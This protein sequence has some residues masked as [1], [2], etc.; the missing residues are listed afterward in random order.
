[1]VG[2]GLPFVLIF[3]KTDKLSRAAAQANIDAFLLRLQEIS[4][5]AP[6]VLTSSSTLSHGRSEILELIETTLAQAPE[7]REAWETIA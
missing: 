3:T 7:D 1:M 2:C 4:P 6:P 5:D